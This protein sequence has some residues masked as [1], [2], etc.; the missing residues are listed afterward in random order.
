M[1]LHYISLSVGLA[2]CFGVAVIGWVFLKSLSSTWV[3]I[4]AI[5][6]L[7]LYE[8]LPSARSI[9]L[10]SLE[11]STKSNAEIRCVTSFD[12]VRGK[13]VYEAL[14]YVWGSPTGTTPICCN[15]KELLVTP[16]CHDALRRL[17]RR[18]SPRVLW[19]DAICID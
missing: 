15:G 13:D 17:R 14:P 2:P 7:Y 11:P 4:M 9:R 6:Q 5:I 19:I 1:Q 18:F 10:V 16:N 8:P 3:A 12:S